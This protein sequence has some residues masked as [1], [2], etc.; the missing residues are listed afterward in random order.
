[1]SLEVLFI[2]WFVVVAAITVMWIV[3]YLQYRAMVNR[4]ER[5]ILEEFYTELENFYSELN[6]INQIMDGTK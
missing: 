5:D 4:F 1:M 3:L 6:T 2:T